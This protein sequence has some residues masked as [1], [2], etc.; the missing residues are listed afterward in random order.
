MTIQKYV[1]KELTHFVGGILSDED[2]QY[3]LL[4]KILSSGWLTHP[5]HNPNISGNLSVNVEARISRNEMYVP[6]VVCFCD[7]P[8]GD[9][10]IH[11]KKYSRFGLSFFKDFLTEKGANPVFYIAANSIV[12]E[13]PT[14]TLTLIRA[15]EKAKE[16]AVDL[17]D[18]F[19]KVARASLFDQRVPEYVDLI[20]RQPKRAFE[21]STSL[22]VPSEHLEIRD[23]DQFISFQILS[24]IKFFDDRKADDDPENFYMEREWR[25]VGNIRFNLD[26]VERVILPR[27]DSKRLREALPE[28]C[29]QVTFSD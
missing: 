13:I 17:R 15:A 7:I 6:Q 29:G 19:K 18:S 5:P 1:S 11:M 9:L 10:D 8:V 26:D 14:D 23:I 20:S 28:Y 22:E 21:T 12:H 3:E 25:V 27:A 16:K 4:L 2:E 24:F